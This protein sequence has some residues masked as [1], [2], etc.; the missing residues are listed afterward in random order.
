MV[1]YSAFIESHPNT[2]AIHCYRRKSSQTFFKNTHHHRYSQNASFFDIFRNH[3]TVMFLDVYSAIFLWLLFTH[4]FVGFCRIRWFE[5]W[6]LWPE[7]VGHGWTSDMCKCPHVHWNTVLHFY[8]IYYSN[9]WYYTGKHWEKRS[10]VWI[11]CRLLQG[12]QIRKHVL[13]KAKRNVRF[14]SGQ[15]SRSTVLGERVWNSS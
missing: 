6:D 8:G 15:R 13:Y 9:A 2:L 12:R 5:C 14:T 11:F 10:Y 3:F 4:T 7:S 1:K